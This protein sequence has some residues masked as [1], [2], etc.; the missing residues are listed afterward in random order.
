MDTSDLLLERWYP[1][2][3]G[4]PAPAACF[5][6]KDRF[7]A[8][9]LRETWAKLGP[10]ERVV[11]R[12]PSDAA[13]R[14]RL[15]RL[16]KILEPTDLRE[17]FVEFGQRDRRAVL[18]PA[19]EG[20]AFRGS[21]DLLPSDLPGGR[22]L[23]ALLRL[24][25]PF[26]LAQRF[27]RSEVAVWTRLGGAL[28]DR[29]LPILPVGGRLAVLVNLAAPEQ[30]VTVRALDRRGSIRA[31][32][33]VGASAASE[34]SVRREIEAATG[35]RDPAPRYHASV[36]ASGERGGS[37]WLAEE[38][39]SS[40]PQTESVA[41]GAAHAGFLLDLLERRGTP[42]SLGDCSHFV[43]SW[44]HLASLWRDQDPEWH[45]DHSRLA[46]TLESAV[47]SGQLPTS[48]A[49]GDFTPWTASTEPRSL[50]LSNW[51]RFA[52]S[53]PLLYDLFHFFTTSPHG[54]AAPGSSRDPLSVDAVWTT[55]SDALAGEG[56]TVIDASGLS[57]SELAVH[58][59]VTLLFDSSTAELQA[60]LAPDED[61]GPGP[62]RTLRH[63]LVRR[64]REVLDG[65]RRGPWAND[66]ER[67]EA[68]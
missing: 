54:E 47:S 53:A 49:H 1:P 60:R 15:A 41:F 39:A 36:V 58:L 9:A 62:L 67:L 19:D 17:T 2:L 13:T 57:E 28:P 21:L 68:A 52:P 63:E 37:P 55:L 48:P 14:T 40:P 59:A 44:R 33:R 5:D 32:L 45:D 61:G 6:L 4:G 50:R 7:A 12:T 35:L 51:S 29:D 66:D 42:T 25:S 30:P 16:E 11:V 23:I 46:R 26:S 64:C 24:A 22:A 10:G 18:L 20:G 8:G 27:G 65:E 31:T 34:A 56:R 3:R 38:G 43:D